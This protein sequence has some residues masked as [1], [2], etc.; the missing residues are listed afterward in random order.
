MRISII[1]SAL[2]L[3]LLVIVLLACSKEYDFNDGYDKPVTLDTT[4]VGNIDTSMFKIDSSGFPE[5]RRFPGLVNA[6]EPRLYNV[7]VELDLDYKLVSPNLRIASAPGFWMSTG[8]YAAPGELIKVVVPKGTEGLSIQVGSHTDNVN[9]KFPQLRAGL[10][11]TEKTLLPGD[12]FIRNIYGGLIYIIPGNPSKKKVTL[13]FSHVCKSPDFVLGQTTDAAWKE[14]VRKSQVP[15]VELRSKRF[16]LTAYRKVLLGMLENFSAEAVMKLWD[17]AIE[18]DYHEWYGLSDNPAD[19]IDQAPA[20]QHRF[21]LDIQISLGSGHSGY[22]AMAYLDWHPEFL[23][24]AKINAGA[25]WGPFHEIGHNF[26]MT[27]MWSWSGADALTEVSNNLFVFKIAARHG[28]KPPRTYDAGQNFVPPALAFAAGNGPKNFSSL[29]D[30]FS[31]LVPFVQ[32]FQRYGY[33]MM[34]YICTAARHEQRVSYINE[35]KKNF[36]YV[37]AS[38]YAGVNL[39]PFFDQWGIAVSPSAVDQVSNLPLLTEQIWLNDI[40]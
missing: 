23:D 9:G 27:S 26:Q 1:R 32:L 36:F 25:S 6:V 14:A 5:A 2:G 40:R 28:K 18:K 31:R 21:V 7:P 4:G 13:A 8:L 19:P 22:P 15:V 10:I 34:G 33:G 11:T 29:S 12:N 24:T 38:K 39:K 37:H 30:V 16:V 20:T 17:E 3:S 35:V